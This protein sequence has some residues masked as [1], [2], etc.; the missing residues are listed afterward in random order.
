[1]NAIQLSR[2]TGPIANGA[3]AVLEF[4]TGGELKTLIPG[5]GDEPSIIAGMVAVARQNRQFAPFLFH[6]AVNGML[7]YQKAN[8][9]FRS[10]IQNSTETSKKP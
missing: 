4:Q 1:M 8:S 9:L 6:L 7:P 10:Q 3:L 5:P 2:P